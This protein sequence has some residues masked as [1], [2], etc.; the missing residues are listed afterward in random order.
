M[1]YDLANHKWRTLSDDIYIGS[2]KI[3]EIY[4]GSHK[5]YPEDVFE[6]KWIPKSWNYPDGDP[7]E[8]DTRQLFSSNGNIYYLDKDTDVFYI[9]DK[10]TYSW[11][12]ITMKVERYIYNSRTGYKGTEITNYI[13]SFRFSS[14]CKLGGLNYAMRFNNVYPDYGP[15]YSVVW[16]NDSDL[17]WYIY[18]WTGDVKPGVLSNE[19]IWT[20]GIDQYITL[21]NKNYKY[22]NSHSWEEVTFQ[23][24]FVVSTPA[25]VWNDN[26][27][28]YYSPISR[29][30]YKFD[31]S[32][33]LWT[34]KRFN[35]IADGIFIWNFNGVS[36]Y[37]KWYKFNSENE[38]WEDVEFDVSQ[39]PDLQGSF[40]AYRVWTDGT[41]TYYSNKYVLT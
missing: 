18:E 40:K 34:P 24:S 33:L 17:T 8:I 6:G 35:K 31:R 3:Q 26:F 20:D 25:F 5:I 1:S 14:L 15:M 28:T 29:N 13:R 7:F 22:T 38:T 9:L 2:H 21:S 16:F 23:N 37:T 4:V 27:N 12:R 36:Y 32:S 10:E 19:D 39:A 30:G 11:R 41:N